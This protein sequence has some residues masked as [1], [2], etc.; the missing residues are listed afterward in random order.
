MLGTLPSLLDGLA[1]EDGCESSRNADWDQ[2]TQGHQ[3]NLRKDVNKD[4]RFIRK[5]AA[6]AWVPMSTAELVCR[7]ASHLN[8]SGKPEALES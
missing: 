1:G 7:V 4:Q 5:G 2:G 3:N 8:S 6:V